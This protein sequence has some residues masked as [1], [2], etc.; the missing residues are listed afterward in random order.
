MRRTIYIVLNLSLLLFTVNSSLLPS[1]ASK[2]SFDPELDFQIQ[3]LDGSEVMLS[4]YT[5]NSIILD[6]FASW[7]Q[8]CITQ[9]LH[10]RVIQS[11]YPHVQIISVSVDL[12]DDIAILVQFQASNNMTW[13]V[14]RDITREG[15]LKYNASSIPSVAYF[16]SSGELTHWK[17]GVTTSSTLSEWIE[18]ETVIINTTSLSS[19]ISN[20]TTTTTST[21]IP[22][23]TSG[24]DVAYI[25]LIFIGIIT[26]LSRKR[27]YSKKSQ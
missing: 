21:S 16:D 5:G 8:P 18:T 19:N 25:L 13:I 4:N 11:N 15:A 2:D 23:L 22:T 20:Q 1:V 14:G 26:P 9:I 7:A 10:Y 17:Q 3:L 27:N 24:F 6:F 12:S